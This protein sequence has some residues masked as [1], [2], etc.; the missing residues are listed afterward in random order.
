[1]WAVVTVVEAEGDEGD[2]GVD[3]ERGGE[4]VVAE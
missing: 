2:L 3:E 1:M 4:M